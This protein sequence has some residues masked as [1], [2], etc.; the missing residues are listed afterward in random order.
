[1][2]GSTI[3]FLLI[4]GID[5]PVMKFV[6]HGIIWVESVESVDLVGFFPVMLEEMLL[7]SVFGTYENEEAIS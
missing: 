1:M 4:E 2:K 6:E 7:L 3:G 5:L